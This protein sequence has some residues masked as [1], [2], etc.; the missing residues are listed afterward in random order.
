M[1]KA[2]PDEE[3]INLKTL[4]KEIRKKFDTQFGE[5]G[6]DKIEIEIGDPPPPSEKSM[7]RKLGGYGK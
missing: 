2:E 5:L 4:E 1:K 3:M 7:F 6:V